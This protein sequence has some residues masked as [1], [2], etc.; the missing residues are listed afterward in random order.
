MPRQ[1]RA[2]GKVPRNDGAVMTMIASMSLTGMGP[3]LG[4]DAA[5]ALVC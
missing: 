2:G 4:L 1:G 3:A 5:V